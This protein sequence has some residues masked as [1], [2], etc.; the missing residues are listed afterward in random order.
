ME[1]VSKFGSEFDQL[2]KSVREFLL[3]SQVRDS[4]YLTW[5]YGQ[6]PLPK[7]V[8]CFRENGVLVAYAALIVSGQGISGRFQNLV[9]MD[10]IFDPRRANIASTILSFV[11]NMAITRQINSISDLIS[12]T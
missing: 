11:V 10:W 12:M 9:L 4:K 8:V 2:W 1:T 6:S 5:R 7:E 3:I